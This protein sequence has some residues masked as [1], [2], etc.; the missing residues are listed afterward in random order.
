MAMSGSGGF[1]LSAIKMCVLPPYYIL[2]QDLSLV[3]YDD[4]TASH[5]LVQRRQKRALLIPEETDSLMSH[6]DVEALT[7]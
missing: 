7:T 2:I 1:I 3:S 4:P 6:S 5:A